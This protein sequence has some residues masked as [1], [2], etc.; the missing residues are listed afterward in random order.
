[1]G[2]WAPVHDEEWDGDMPLELDRPLNDSKSGIVTF[3]DNTLP[4]IAG[5]YEVSAIFRVSS[6]DVHVYIR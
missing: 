5:R 4:W 6:L 3:K 1:M 2:M